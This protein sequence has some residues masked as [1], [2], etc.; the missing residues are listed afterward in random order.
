MLLFVVSSLF[1][2]EN[3][4]NTNVLVPGGGGTQ[5]FSGSG[6]RPGFPKC[7]ACELTFASE[8]GGL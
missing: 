3:S 8:K 5:L 6:V 7:E 2:Q 4:F 1:I